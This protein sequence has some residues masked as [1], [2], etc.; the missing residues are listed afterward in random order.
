MGRGQMPA[1][2]VAAVENGLQPVLRRLGLTGWSLQGDTTMVL[3][4]ALGA[5]CAAV[6]SGISNRVFAYL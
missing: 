4:A 6:A 1:D 3:A 2:V 5:A